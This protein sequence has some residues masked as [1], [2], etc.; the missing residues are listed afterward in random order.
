MA[1]L[2]GSYGE[3]MSSCTQQSGVPD[4][5][6]DVTRRRTGDTF[7]LATCQGIVGSA[8]RPTEVRYCSRADSAPASTMAPT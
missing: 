2:Q 5:R 6:G 3:S 8:A 1:S 4:I 7:C